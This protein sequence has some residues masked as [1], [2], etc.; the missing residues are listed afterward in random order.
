MGTKGRRNVI[1][2]VNQICLPSHCKMQQQNSENS[3]MKQYYPDI[4]NHKE[5]HKKGCVD[6]AIAQQR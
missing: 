5:L 6:E 2:D 4:N 3:T 1:Q